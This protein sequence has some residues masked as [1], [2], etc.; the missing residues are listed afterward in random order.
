M[1]DDFIPVLRGYIMWNFWSL[2]KD[3][4]LDSEKTHLLGKK[5]YKRKNRKF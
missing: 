1:R 4:C 3:Y 5:I 2:M